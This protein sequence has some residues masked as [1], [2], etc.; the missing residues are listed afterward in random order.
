MQESMQNKEKYVYNGIIAHCD[1]VWKYNTSR[2]TNII[3]S[4]FSN[5]YVL[6][7]Y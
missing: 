3:K 5:W 6:N 7:I 4:V 1:H 2:T